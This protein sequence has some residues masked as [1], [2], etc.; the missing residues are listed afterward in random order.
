MRI[1]GFRFSMLQQLPLLH[2]S[3]L[4]IGFHTGRNT[5]VI[6]GSWISQY[7]NRVVA[8]MIISNPLCSG[9]ATDLC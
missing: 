6:S 9:L 4:L 2:I 8:C 1:N 7:G 5:D 3:R